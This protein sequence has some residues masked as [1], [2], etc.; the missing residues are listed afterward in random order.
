MDKLMLAIL[1]AV[2]GGTG[3]GIYREFNPTAET[4]AAR[5]AK[6]EQQRIEA[7]KQKVLIEKVASENMKSTLKTMEG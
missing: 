5:Q 4:I 6:I 7:E 1:L 3:Y 2:I